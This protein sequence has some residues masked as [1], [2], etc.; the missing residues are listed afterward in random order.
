MVVE[1][2]PG[3]CGVGRELLFVLKPHLLNSSGRTLHMLTGS[4]MRKNVHADKTDLLVTL[5]IQLVYASKNEL[6]SEKT[7]VFVMFSAKCRY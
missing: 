1:S 5:G 2:S 3:V 6:F 7:V 4:A